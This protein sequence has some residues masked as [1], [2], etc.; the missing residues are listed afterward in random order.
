[1]GWWGCW[2]EVLVF[3]QVLDDQMMTADYIDDVVLVGGASWPLM[4]EDVVKVHHHA[5]NHAQSAI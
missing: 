3:L 5:Q 1:M 2:W 4:G